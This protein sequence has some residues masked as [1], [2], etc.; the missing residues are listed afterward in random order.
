[1]VRIL[2]WRVCV[3][4]K[5]HQPIENQI[6]EKAERHDSGHR[7]VGKVLLPE[8][9]RFREEVEEGHPDDRTGTE[10]EDEV[11]LVPQPEGYQATG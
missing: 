2:V 8:L 9:H 6:G 11:K 10:A 1:M 5:E 4:M 3:H 7:T